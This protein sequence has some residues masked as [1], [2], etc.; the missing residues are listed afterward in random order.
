MLKQSA[1]GVLAVFPPLQEGSVETDLLEVLPGPSFALV[2]AGHG[3]S[4]TEL[5]LSPVSL[6]LWNHLSS[7]FQAKQCYYNNLL[8]TCGMPVGKTR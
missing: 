3:T 7:R 2:S 4:Y 1:A 8:D 5:L 6:T